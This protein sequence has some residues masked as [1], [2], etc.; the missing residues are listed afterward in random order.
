M[1]K[2][3]GKK[4]RGGKAQCESAS[5]EA[6]LTQ[7][8]E[9][10]LL[11]FQNVPNPQLFFPY[12][13]V[14]KDGVMVM[15]ERLDPSAQSMVEAK[16]DAELLAYPAPSL[17]ELQT[18]APDK[19]RRPHFSAAEFKAA[20]FDPDYG[21]HYCASGV[22]SRVG[23]AQFRES[24]KQRAQSL[25]QSRDKVRN[26]FEKSPAYLALSGDFLNASKANKTFADRISHANSLAETMVLFP[27]LASRF[28]VSLEDEIETI[29]S[30]KFYPV[31]DGCLADLNQTVEKMRLKYV[32]ALQKIQSA[33]KTEQGVSPGLMTSLNSAKKEWDN[34]KAVRTRFAVAYEKFRQMVGVGV[35]IVPW[36]HYLLDN[37]VFFKEWT[38]EQAEY[39]KEEYSEELMQNPAQIARFAVTLAEDWAREEMAQA[40]LLEQ[41]CIGGASPGSAPGALHAAAGGDGAPAAPKEEP[42]AEAAFLRKG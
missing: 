26:D 1:G 5:R 30:D 38:R 34:W 31:L 39:E 17:L 2:K 3:K 14:E 6:L 15:T 35:A 20:G 7:A 21:R 16:R 9:G 42:G 40:A 11:N 24:L 8:V 12:S 27:E 32:A 10:V 41:P 33:K 13:F 36:M 37:P 22:G 25:P 28:F 19:D 23:A 18:G 29:I 4:A